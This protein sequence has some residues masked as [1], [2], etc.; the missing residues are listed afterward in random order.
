MLTRTQPID[1]PREQVVTA[2]T[3]LRQDWQVSAGEK[4][5]VKIKG[6][7]GLILSDVTTLLGLDTIERL[8][9]LGDEL[10]R[11]VEDILKTT[12]SLR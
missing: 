8:R 12:Y 2:L 4:S 9:V 5:L 6:N 11:E 7:V 3:Q 1:I 10:T